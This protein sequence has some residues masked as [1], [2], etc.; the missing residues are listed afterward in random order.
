M[1]RLR[2]KE[3]S[4]ISE[5]T[6]PLLCY[7]GHILNYGTEKQ[8]RRISRILFSFDLG[9]IVLNPGLVRGKVPADSSHL[10]YLLL[11]CK[12]HRELRSNRLSCVI[13]APSPTPR[14]LTWRRT[15][16]ETRPKPAKK[17]VG[18]ALRLADGRRRMHPQSPSQPYSV[19]AP[20]A[21][22]ASGPFPAAPKVSV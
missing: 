17:T 6:Y 15:S 3:N 21:R 22:I 8:N 20:R 11:K 4:G 5:T 14:E 12:L 9:N 16:T 18:A 10:L 1:A 13:S 19:I 7:L 2:I